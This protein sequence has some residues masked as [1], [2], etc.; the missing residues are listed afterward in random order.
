M[1]PSSRRLSRPIRRDTFRFVKLPRSRGTAL[2]F[3]IAL[4]AAVSLALLS[5]ARSEGQADEA[6]VLSLS[7]PANGA[8]ISEPPFAIQ[9]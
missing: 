2:V 6:L 3:T 1:S 9:L 7:S 8:T 5:P 4:L